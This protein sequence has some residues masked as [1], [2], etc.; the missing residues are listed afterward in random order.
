MRN[1]TIIIK[2]TKNHQTRVS[3][4]ND[5]TNRNED[6]DLLEK[7]RNVGLQNERKN[8][9]IDFLIG[10]SINKKGALSPNGDD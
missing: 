2:E 5:I 9:Q 6:E 10:H 4:K 8:R 3:T 7:R 1:K